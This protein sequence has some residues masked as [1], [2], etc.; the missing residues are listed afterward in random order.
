LKIDHNLNK[1]S[2]LYIVAEFHNGIRR[3][4]R[5]TRPEKNHEIHMDRISRGTDAGSPQSFDVDA[6]VLFLA[7]FRKY[8][9]KRFSKSH[10][11]TWVHR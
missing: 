6:Q 8:H 3:F 10:Q 4:R 2:A 11:S 5:R 9:A 1:I 7:L